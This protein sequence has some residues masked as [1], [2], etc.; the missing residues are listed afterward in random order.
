[1]DWNEK[2]IMLEYLFDIFKREH[3]NVNL[4]MDC[5]ASHNVF[6]ITYNGW[7]ITSWYESN[8]C[9]SWYNDEYYYGNGK[10]SF[11]IFDLKDEFSIVCVIR[12]F[13][14]NY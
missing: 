14:W 10:D 6:R 13:T 12:S 1:M 3:P 8:P 2:K 7:T 5:D 4:V 9:W 11:G